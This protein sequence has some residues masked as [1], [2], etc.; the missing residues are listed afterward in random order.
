MSA[1]WWEWVILPLGSLV[2]CYAPHEKDVKRGC[3]KENWVQAVAETAIDDSVS[4]WWLW[5]HWATQKKI[6]SQNTRECL[7]S[8]C[9]WVS[10]KWFIH[11]TF[12]MNLLAFFFFFNARCACEG[13]ELSL[14]FPEGQML[15]FC[16]ALRHQVTPTVCV[17][18]E[19]YR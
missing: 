11:K 12:S 8:F 4:A 18:V 6:L 1:R 7:N 2:L 17:Y 19:L 15:T 13:S 14:L 5:C 3:W 9:Q 10:H 16:K